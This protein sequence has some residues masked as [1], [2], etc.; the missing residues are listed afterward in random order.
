MLEVIEREN[1]DDN[2]RARGEELRQGLEALA[3]K[4][5]IQGVRGYGGL[6]GMVVH[7]DPL[8]AIARLTEAGLLLIPAAN[9][10]VRFLPPLNV[11]SEEIAEALRIVTATL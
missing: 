1:L 9:Q 11:T 8:A 5:A 6:V 2:I 7:G 10:T 4:S 3:A